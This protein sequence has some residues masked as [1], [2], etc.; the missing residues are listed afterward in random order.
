MKEWSAMLGV[1]LNS[2]PHIATR[3]M[4]GFL[5]FYGNG[6]IF[7]ALPQTRGFDSPSSMIFKFHPMA[8]KLLKRAEAD[9][10]PDTSTW[11]PGQGWVSFQL[12]SEADLRDALWWLNQAYQ[13][14]GR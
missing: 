6:T 11:V 5:S 14:A 13:A 10:R 3:K 9:E 4:F 1:G 12:R 8:P 7:A 2:W